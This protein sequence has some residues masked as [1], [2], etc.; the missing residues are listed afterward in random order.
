MK[1]IV[2]RH[3][4]TEGNLQR[5]YIGITDEPLC[6]SGIELAKQASDAIKDRAEAVYCSPLKRC[7]ETAE[8][9]FPNSNA[10][11]VA[12][13]RECSFGIFEGMTHA[14]LANNADY[15]KWVASEGA[16]TPPGGESGADADVRC[17]AAF[18]YL[19][20]D[21]RLCRLLMC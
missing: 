21:M 7:V 9:L 4:Y 16:F 12:Q 10:V 19:L 15:I 11:T 8:I 17:A 5:R 6:Q 3:S 1:L 18:E 13:L 14:E 2:I 20:N